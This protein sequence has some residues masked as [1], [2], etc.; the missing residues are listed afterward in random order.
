MNQRAR[1]RSDFE[2]S[3]WGAGRKKGCSI[4]FTTQAWG[5]DSLGNNVLN[6]G[7]K[8]T[9]DETKGKDFGLEEGE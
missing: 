4:L 1:D 7:Y 5:T 9:F 3:D 2:A 6:Q 8:R